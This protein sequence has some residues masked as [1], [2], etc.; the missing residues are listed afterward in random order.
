MIAEDPLRYPTR[1]SRHDAMRDPVRVFDALRRESVTALGGVLSGFWGTIEE[2]VR[3]EA[4][5]GHDYSGAQDDRMAVMALGHRALELAT[6]YRES[7]EREFDAWRRPAVEQD[8]DTSLSLM[9]E[10]ELEIHLAGQHITELLDH[11]FL[12]PLE[13][14]GERLEAL[15]E[16]L[17][18][19]GK[20][21]NPVRP[22]AT[23]AAFIGLFGT[24]DLT[25]G[26]R[27]L[28][29]N[30]FDKRLPE[31]LGELYE[32]LNA[33]LEEAGFGSGSDSPDRVVRRPA[34]APGPGAGD[35]RAYAGDQAGDA[36]GVWVPDG[37]TVEYSVRGQAGGDGDS[38]GGAPAGG[39]PGGL[40]QAAAHAAAAE[41]R[42]LRYRD[43]VREHLADWR[44]AGLTAGEGPSTV[45]PG[46]QVL[47]TE[48]LLNVAQILQ[49]DD[50]APYTRALAVSDARELGR[51]IREA[52]R[53]GLRQLGLDAD[54]AHFSV[55][56]EDAIDLVGMLFSSINGANDLEGRAR[57]FFGRLI[58]P[59]L[60]VALTDDSMFNRRSHP[61]RRLLD[62]LTEACDG[63]AGET[64]QD[65]ETLDRA[66]RAV[67]RVVEEYDEDQA[68]F[69]LAASELRDQLEQ[70]RRRTEL[71]EKRA[72]EAI[73]GRERLQ[74]ART[75][76]ADLV[77][78]RLSGRML[79]ASVARFLD[80]DWR[81]HLTQAWLRDGPGSPR[82][83]QAI[84]LGDAMVQVDADAAQA[85]GRVVAE[86]LLALQV[87]LGECY[88]SCGM[89]AAAAR[90]AM[91]RIISDLGL[92][93]AARRV[94]HPEGGVDDVE[95]AVDESPLAGLRLAGGTDT[96]D[97][98][99]E[100]AAR[101]RRLRVGQGL[102]LVE[103]GQ[104]SA[105]RIAWIS[106]LTGRFL[107]VNR[108]G[109]RKMVVSPEEL[110]VLVAA[111]RV[112][113]RSTDAPFDEAMRQVWKHLGSMRDPER[114]A[115]G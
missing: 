54:A 55:D 68:I 79:T 15:A 64:P 73:H 95:P 59:Y 23:V 45:P 94:H 31:V 12:H 39:G 8:A 108:R 72:G 24:E 77:A 19:E 38:A 6:R 44:A 48:D 53:G 18:V 11:Q 57:D 70:Q 28:V 34:P 29:F 40:V 22:V 89:D 49:G 65:R 58:V 102:R 61:A 52:I 81:H 111:G 60:K 109:M 87:P 25:R 21:A 63:N 112:V 110:S 16:A 92:P 36:G 98:D 90:D 101:M 35:G 47:R 51:V 20:R 56:E 83:R 27:P 17:G 78:S 30:Q 105:A 69:E 104:E 114:A 62:V 84:A 3:L 42:P 88:S 86:Q 71:A 26:L 100:V 76:A 13:Q 97:F 66:E 41:G 82:H 50:A 107:V 14:L 75:H 9:S 32:K 46:A 91:A 1:L 5:A 67:D 115:N 96:F 74:Q 106:P 7:L 85:R 4:L 33:L 93:D 103:D 43:V 10:G 99:P 37:G 80:H 113:V 2:Q